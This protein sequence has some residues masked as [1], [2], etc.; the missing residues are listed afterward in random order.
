MKNKFAQQIEQDALLREVVDDV[1][2]EQ[3]RKMWDKYGLFVIIGI[4]LVLTVT[5]SF[6]SIKNWQMKKYQEISDADSV[7]LSLQNQGRLDE[8]L[9]VYKHL[10]DKVSGIYADLA[11]LQ[12]AAIYTEQDKSADAQNVLQLVSTDG[13][14]PQM[15][16]IAALKLAADKL[17]NNAP[18]EEIENILNPLIERENPIDMAYELLAMLYIREHQINKA[19]IEYEMIRYSSTATEAMKLRALDMMNILEE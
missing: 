19:L 3:F 13:N 1:K 5:I 12:I 7:G 9:E 4:A 15:R 8:S 6:E 14:L 10:A 11:R 17:N 18:A 16:D 2:E